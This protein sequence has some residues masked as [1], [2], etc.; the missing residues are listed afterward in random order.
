M[1]SD[2]TQ[3][4]TLGDSS[5][6]VKLLYLLEQT[7]GAVRLSQLV[8]VAVTLVDSKDDSPESVVGRGS[9]HEI[10]NTDETFR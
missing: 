3:W 6:N 2:R 8:A 1:P 4:R 5:D 10:K 7:V 9:W